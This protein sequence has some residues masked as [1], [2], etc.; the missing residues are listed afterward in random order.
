MEKSLVVYRAVFKGTYKSYIGITNNLEERKK[1][2]LRNCRRGMKNKFYDAIRKY[3]EPTFELLTECATIEELYETERY[4]IEKYD[5]Y[6]NGLNLTLGGEGSFGS[7]RPKD[8]EWRNEHSHR[9]TVANPRTGI[10][11][12]DEEKQAHSQKMKEYYSHHPSKKAWGNKSALGLIWITNGK[13]TKKISKEMNVP[14]G[15]RRGRK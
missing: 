6:H 11:Y 13:E 9:M 10:K 12:K 15:W 4:Y 5:T 3:G 14:E 8:D 2:H 1:T 7:S